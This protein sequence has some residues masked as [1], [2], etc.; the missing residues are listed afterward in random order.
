M[1]VATGS[2]LSTI[3]LGGWKLSLYRDGKGLS[4]NHS[5]S[6]T[7]TSARNP[8]VDEYVSTGYLN[9]WEKR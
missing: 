1:E 4:Y 6:S 3:T 8:N 9:K 7:I 5:I 2:P